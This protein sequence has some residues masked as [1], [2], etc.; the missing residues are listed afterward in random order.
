MVCRFIKPTYFEGV[1]M[2]S[3]TKKLAALFSLLFAGSAFSAAADDSIRLYQYEKGAWGALKTGFST[4]SAI[5]LVH[6]LEFNTMAQVETFSV[7]K[8]L[9]LC[10]GSLLVVMVI[11]NSLHASAHQNGRVVFRPII[12]QKLKIYAPVPIIFS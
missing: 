1:F 5:V 12:L 10:S 4:D 9:P 3:I 8:T 11:S 7:S 2:T 6:G